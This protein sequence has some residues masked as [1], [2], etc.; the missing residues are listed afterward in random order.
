MTAEALFLNGVHESVLRGIIDAQERAGP[1]EISYLQ[2]YKSQAIAKFREDSPTAHIPTTLYLSTTDN[3]S[4][5]SYRA[6]IVGWKDKTSLDES[7]R[8]GID[9]EIR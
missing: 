4:T 3:L 7:E 9:G 1:D 2:P 5:V 6:Q 8:A